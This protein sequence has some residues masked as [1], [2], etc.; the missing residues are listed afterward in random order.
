MPNNFE[1][2]GKK[3]V[4]KDAL[5]K[6]T[7]TALYTADIQLDDVL[8]GSIFRSTRHAA[9][10]KSLDISSAESVPGVVKV[11]T[12]KDI[13]GEKAFGALV[14]D[15][16]S[17]VLDEVRFFGEPIAIVVADS[18]TTADEAVNMIK[19]VYEDLTPVFD[20][21]A[22]LE[23]NAR[24][25]YAD[26]NLLTRYEVE[27]GDLQSGFKSADIILE[28][29]FSVPRISPG[30]MEPENSLA[31]WND[32]GSVTVWVN[33]QQPFHDQEKIA[34]VLGLPLDKV[35]VVGA[36]IGGAFGGKEDPAT[37]ILTAL[38]TYLTKKNV[39]ICNERK[40][41]FLGHP[42]RHPATLTLKLGAT[43]A[44]VL[45]ALDAKV[46]MD[47][48]AFASYGPAVGGLLTET[49]GGPYRI[50]NM[51]VETKVVYTNSPLSGAMRGFGAP[52]S[53]FAIE[54]M[55]DVLAARLKIDPIEI[56]KRN[57]LKSGDAVFTRVVVNNSAD[58]LPKI[59]QKIE[60]YRDKY[61]SIPAKPGMVSGIGYACAAQ[62]M[63][64]GAKVPDNSSHQ[65]TWQQDGTVLL[66]LGAPDLG[67]G[68]ETIAEQVIAEKLGIPFADVVTA[69]LDTKSTP[70]GNVTCASRMTYM[71]G[72][73]VSTAS[74]QLVE[75][76]LDNASKLLRIP[77]SEL[78]YDHGFVIDQ[79]DQSI[80]IA[81][82]L[83]RFAENDVILQTT[84]TA[85]FP[86]PIENTPQ[87]LP[88][89]MPHVMFVF[90]GQIARVEVDPELGLVEVTHLAAIHDVGQVINQLGVE[91]QIEGGVAMG[92]GYA[93][94]EDMR[95]KS[96]GEWVSSF[97][98]Y[99]LPTSKD[100]PYQLDIDILEIPEKSGPFGAKGLAEIC[101][102]PTGA[103]IA[104]AVFNATGK[105]VTHLP[106]SPEDLL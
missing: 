74:D 102:V 27:D 6:V 106:I 80:P 96:N 79:K 64:L 91:G 69:Q 84:G 43:N 57:I 44:G 93:L 99:L 29:T 25:I 38:S 72:N 62:T 95:L 87:H 26:G 35:Q 45:T 63:G 11:I 14:S 68:L 81:D 101:L 90:A 47:T 33:S 34:S 105:R 54:S 28:E 13:P 98:E 30:Y 89:G 66:N 51:K 7:G 21:Q 42:K 3:V 86:Y 92:I 4:R 67:Q 40:D 48:G 83:A 24:K 53:N 23:P 85:S 49:V 65:L 97:T 20:P 59:L 18:K 17:L 37:C 70:D 19:I 103:A 100:M 41:S 8:W 36:V 2:I 71:V 76:L 46:Y 9:R 50:P 61:A 10:I 1:T 12:A 104:N 32:E 39:R 58:S 22:A 73:A 31:R 75:Q 60:E 88:I 5:S 94:Y 15:Q 78:R 56:R 82:I 52:Q 16:V 77:K 55:M